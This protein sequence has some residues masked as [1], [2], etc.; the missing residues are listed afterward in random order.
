MKKRMIQGLAMAMWLAGTTVH[1][2]S[3]NLG[4][5]GKTTAFNFQNFN[6]SDADWDEITCAGRSTQEAAKL[7]LDAAEAQNR[8][9][10]G[11]MCEL[12]YQSMMTMDPYNKGGWR[13]RFPDNA[14]LFDDQYEKIFAQF[15]KLSCPQKV[16]Y[17]TKYADA[18][19]AWAMNNLGFT[20][21]NGSGVAPDITKAI[22]WLE[23]AA[24]KNYVLAMN[25]LGDTYRKGEKLP[26]DPVK[27]CQW[28]LKSAEQESS[29]GQY[30]AGKCFQ[31]GK[32]VTQDFEKAADYYR[33]AAK[34]GD[35][36]AEERLKEM[37][38]NG[39]IKKR[40]GLF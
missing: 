32:G 35:E 1:A 39:Q 17:Y 12:A 19:E 33:K 22:G 10:T 31:D 18:G 11:R 27:A 2:A 38:K 40:F 5:A 30:Y 13:D 26:E 36:D 29:Y 34:Q 8:G 6:Q 7:M 16:T 25:N 21:L 37:K 24:E 28:Y 14:R 9:E 3:C 15:R 4:S 23:K 20:Y